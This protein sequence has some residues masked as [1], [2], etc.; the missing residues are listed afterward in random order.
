MA[1]L[2]FTVLSSGLDDL[3]PA[4]ALGADVQ[5]LRLVGVCAEQVVEHVALRELAPDGNPRVARDEQA[6]A[7]LGGLVDALLLLLGEVQQFRPLHAVERGLLQ[8]HQ[9]V[10]VEHDVLRR[11]VVEHRHGVLRDAREQQ[12]ELAPLVGKAGEVVEHRRVGEQRLHLLHIEPCAHVAL[13]VEVHAVAHRLAHVDEREDQHGVRQV[14]QVEVHDAAREV[15]VGLAVE[16]VHGTLD[17]ALVA[18]R[19]GL[20]LMLRLL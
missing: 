9:E 4:L 19:D 12:A 20:G 3:V 13:G 16:E 11:L 5:L 8:K 2:T 17:E 6:V 7:R 15:H 14:L 10:G 1:S 18:Q